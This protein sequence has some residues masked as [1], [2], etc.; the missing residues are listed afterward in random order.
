MNWFKNLF[1]SS[2]NKDNNEIKDLLAQADTMIA[3]GNVLLE[4]TDSLLKQLSELSDEEVQYV[5]WFQSLPEEH[6]QIVELCGQ[7]GI[8]VNKDNFQ[9]I[10]QKLKL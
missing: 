3:E 9:E 7:K 1:S 8:N 2:R 4:D 6:K 10:L 5:N